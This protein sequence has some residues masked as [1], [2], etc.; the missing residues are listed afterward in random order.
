MTDPTEAKKLELTFETKE[1]LYEVPPVDLKLDL[2]CAQK[3]R[4]FAIPLVGVNPEIPELEVPSKQRTF[5]VNEME[6]E[7]DMDKIYMEIAY[8][9]R[10]CD[11]LEYVYDLKAAHEQSLIERKEERKK[12]E[13]AATAAAT[14]ETPLVK[15]KDAP[16]AG[17]LMEEVLNNSLHKQDCRKMNEAEATLFLK[18]LKKSGK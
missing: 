14:N 2:S 5:A 3:E 9:S 8:Q 12:A 6:L 13:A 15:I 16:Q 10:L 4:S 18:K 7:T 1:R 11:F 17:A